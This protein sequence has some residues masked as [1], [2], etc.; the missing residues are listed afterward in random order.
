M[1][2]GD[3]LSDVFRRHFDDA[4]IEIPLM[5]RAISRHRAA[6]LVASASRLRG[7]SVRIGAD[8]VA[9]IA[10]ELEV[11]ARAYDLRGAAP[12]VASLERALI[13]TRA[14]LAEPRVR[15]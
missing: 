1:G 6:S 15:T 9:P 2:Q 12:L 14:A 10:A 11:R 5:E 4:D 3:V 7:S 8:V 13:Q